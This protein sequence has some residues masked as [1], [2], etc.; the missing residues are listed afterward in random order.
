MTTMIIVKMTHKHV[1][2]EKNSLLAFH[3]RTAQ[4]TEVQ[5][6]WVLSGVEHESALPCS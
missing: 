3:F 2:I 5:I 6:P 4:F 1:H